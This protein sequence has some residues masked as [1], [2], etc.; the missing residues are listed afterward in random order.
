[1]LGDPAPV[2]ADEATNGSRGA[3]HVAAARHY[4]APKHLVHHSADAPLFSD[5]RRVPTVP[6]CI[7]I[8]RP[9]NALISSHLN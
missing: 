2:S 7:S 8:I 9:I 4:R 5:G 1:M 6:R 3:M